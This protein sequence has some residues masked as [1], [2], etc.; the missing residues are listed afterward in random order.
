MKSITMNRVDSFEYLLSM[1]KL[2]F[3]L[4]TIYG[5]SFLTKIIR[6]RRYEM[7]EKVIDSSNAINTVS[8]RI[9]DKALSFAARRDDHR[10]LSLINTLYEKVEKS[11]ERL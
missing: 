11:R 10:L 8:L 3:N 9:I 4:E 7:L 2:N 6:Y 5:E 1:N